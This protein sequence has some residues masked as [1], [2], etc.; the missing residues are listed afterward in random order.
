MKKLETFKSYF[1]EY[2]PNYVLIGGT[3]CSIL[4]D[5]VGLDFRN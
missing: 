4:M 3:A 1:E 5:E 2:R